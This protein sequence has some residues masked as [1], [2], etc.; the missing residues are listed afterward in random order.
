MQEFRIQSGQLRGGSWE[1][2]SFDEPVHAANINEAT[3]QADAR[4]ELGIG[5]SWESDDCVRVLGPDGEM[6]Q[7]PVSDDNTKAWS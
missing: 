3:Q 2:G 6:R 5:I 1:Q 4:I 7:R